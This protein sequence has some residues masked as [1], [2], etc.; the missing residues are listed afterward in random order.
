MLT[1]KNKLIHL[2]LLVALAVTLLPGMALGQAATCSATV[3]VQAGETLSTI[4][5]RTLGNSQ[6]YAQIVT[7]TNAA[8]AVDATYARIDNPNI[9]AV[10]WKLCIPGDS[11]P[12]QPAAQPTTSPLPTTSAATSATNDSNAATADDDELTIEEQW[13]LRSGPDDPH[14]L[15]I[16]YLREQEYPGSAITVEQTLSAGS[17]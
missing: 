3:F 12:V 17:N 1:R 16:E 9:I 8:A 2:G 14:P 5:A 7:A 6:T 11:T 10:G 4:A 13:A 15:T